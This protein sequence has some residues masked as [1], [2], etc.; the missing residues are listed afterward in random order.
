[1]TR[2]R[3]PVAGNRLVFDPSVL[4]IS[5]FSSLK[6]REIPI[7]FPRKTGYGKMYLYSDPIAL[8]HY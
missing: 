5:G 8:A 6:I 4:R 3:H 2:R 7:P 1:M